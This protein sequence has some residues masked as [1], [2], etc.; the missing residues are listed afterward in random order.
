MYFVFA[1]PIYR[2]PNTGCVASCGLTGQD[3]NT[4]KVGPTWLSWGL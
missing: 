4:S 2:M 1:L 3:K